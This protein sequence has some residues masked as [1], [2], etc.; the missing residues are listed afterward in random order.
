MNSPGQETKMDLIASAAGAI[1]NSRWKNRIIMLASALA[2]L[3]LTFA[4]AI[5]FDK[6]TAVVHSVERLILAVL[7]LAVAT[8]SAEQLL[9]MLAQVAAIRF[10]VGGKEQGNDGPK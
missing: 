7:I 8:P 1:E 4:G 2:A 9:K 6:S 3:L 10:G 5:Y